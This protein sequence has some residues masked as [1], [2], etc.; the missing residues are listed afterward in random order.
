MPSRHGAK[1]CMCSVVSLNKLTQ[2]R[3]P[4]SGTKLH[5]PLPQCVLG[6]QPFASMGSAPIFSRMCDLCLPC[7]HNWAL[8]LSAHW[9]AVLMHISLSAFHSC[10]TPGLFFK[11]LAYPTPLR[12]GRS[13]AVVA[14]QQWVPPLLILPPPPSPPLLQKK[15][16]WFSASRSAHFSKANTSHGRTFMVFVLLFMAAR[17]A[18]DPPRWVRDPVLKIQQP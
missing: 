4:A 1:H 16:A 13:S 11:C 3:R 12:G 9:F 10:S 7:M 5:L 6:H 17:L 8:Q 2:G 14:C 15:K 18:Q